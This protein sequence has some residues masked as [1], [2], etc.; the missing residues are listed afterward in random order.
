MDS[1]ILG[2]P[3]T[4]PSHFNLEER[5]NAASAHLNYQVPAGSNIAVFYSEVTAIEGPTST[6]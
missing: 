4:E 2:G 1:L 6:F 5:R 3:T